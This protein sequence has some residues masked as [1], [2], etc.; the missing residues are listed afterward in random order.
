MAPLRRLPRK[1]AAA[2]IAQAVAEHPATASNNTTSCGD[3]LRR[4]PTRETRQTM[5]RKTIFL[6]S[7]LFATL[8]AKASFVSAA[9]GVNGLT[10]SMCARGVEG[11][12]MELPFIDSVTIDLNKLIAHITFKKDVKVSI[13]DVRS[14]IEDAGF[15]VRSIDAV[16]DFSDL[17]VAK[18]FHYAYEGD[19]Y[20]FIGISA[21]TLQG[22][23]RLRFID[24]PYVSKREFGELAKRTL[25]QCYKKGKAA[26]CCVD[27]HAVHGVLYHVTL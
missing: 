19:T 22:Q 17:Q 11:S 10:C 25:F 4:V 23:V 5:L 12:L 18:D 15:S 9:I 27:E 6:V 2:T 7:M 3:T 8:T 1:L 26:S 16:F 20:H 13:D 24:K 21:Q 14:M